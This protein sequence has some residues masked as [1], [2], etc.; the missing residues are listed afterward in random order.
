ML[1]D[2]YITAILVN[3]NKFNETQFVSNLLLNTNYPNLNIVISNNNPQHNKKTVD[4]ANKFKKIHYINNN[5]NIGYSG[6]INKAIKFSFK[7]IKSQF[8]LI[9]NTDVSFDKN[10]LKNLSKNNRKDTIYSPVVLYEGTKLIQNTGGK[11]SIIT[12][13]TININKNKQKKFMKK[14]Q[15]D[16]LSGCCLFFHN[17]IIKNIGFFYEPFE[18]YYEDV[19][20]CFRAVKKNFKLK[21]IWDQFLYHKHSSSTRNNK[22]YKSY[23]II[24]NSIIFAQKNLKSPIKYL[25]IFNSIVTNFLYRFTT[26][27]IS[28]FVKA[29]IS[30]LRWN[31]D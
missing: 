6:G 22:M 3:W 2:Y 10:F 7:N 12:G 21:I 14:I 11:L 27:S 30:G 23:L 5:K 31:N 4:F 24:R 8:F 25:F 17:S 9:L 15:P 20:F 18:S 26:I 16:F 28:K 29:V 13:G 1:E 19:D